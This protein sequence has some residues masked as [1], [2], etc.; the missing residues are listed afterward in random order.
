MENPCHKV[1]IDKL[2]QDFEAE[3]SEK[4]QVGFPKLEAEKM[5]SE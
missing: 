5:A 1:V 4:Q 2:Q 3:I